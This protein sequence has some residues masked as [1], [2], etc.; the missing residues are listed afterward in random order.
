MVP[1]S[2]DSSRTTLSYHE[3]PEP[4]ASTA[5]TLPGTHNLQV[6]FSH[7]QLYVDNLQPLSIYTRI[8]DLLNAFHE[9]AAYLSTVEE[10]A[11]LWKSLIDVS[12]PVGVDGDFE[13]HD[14]DVIYQLLIGCGFRITGYRDIEQG[15][16]TT[17]S[18][19][20]TSKDPAGVQIV[21]TAAA[22]ATDVGRE[23]SEKECIY[24][25]FDV[26]T[27]NHP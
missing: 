13:S 26:G 7:V 1:T 9:Q 17:Q 18:F 3:A 2:Y 19:L 5:S 11:E 15:K 8:E 14:R 22:L 12:S 25:H 10:K 24:S 16:A 6:S 23:H 27:S 4:Y 20:V 21:V